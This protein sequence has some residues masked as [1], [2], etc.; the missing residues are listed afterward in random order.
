MRPKPDFLTPQVAA[1]FQDASVAQAYRFRPAYPVAVFDILVDLIADQP[2]R[3]LDVGCGTGLLARH[4]AER[5][6]WLDAVDVSPEMINQGIQLPGGNH[7][8]LHWILGRVEDAPLHP[9]YSLITAGDSLHWMDW[10]VVMPRFAQMLTAHGMLAILGADQLPTPWDGE[11]LPIRQRYSTIAHWQPYDHVQAIEERGLFRR[12]GVQRTEP[13]TFVQTIDEYIE[14]FH[15]R[16]GFSRDRMTAEA[17]SAFD[18][19]VREL[20]S[21]FSQDTV[22]L[23]IVTEVVWGIPLNPGATG[24]ITA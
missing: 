15:G 7:P 17:A 23:Q 5:V 24:S 9:P 18:A 8:K 22:E 12:V 16:A 20:V 10:D 1:A 11:L 13:V 6:D 19:E 3:V 4:L 14:S 2:R 21:R